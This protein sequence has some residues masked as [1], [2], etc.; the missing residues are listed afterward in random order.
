MPTP[1][2]RS[3]RVKI[4]AAARDTIR[5]KGY[6]ATSVEDLCVGAGVSKGAFFHHF[7]SKEDLAVAAADAWPQTLDDL[8]AA[9]PYHRYA[10]PLERVLGYID[11]RKVILAGDLAKC[12]CLPGTMVQEAFASSPAIRDA[13]GRA[14]IAHCEKI[15]ADIAAAMEVH[16]L[17][18]VWTA[19]SLALHVQAVL[20][21]AFIL[22][23]ACGPEAGA[24][25][26]DHL[27]HYVEML[28][29]PSSPKEKTP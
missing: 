25:S 6:A 5:A 27:R 18:P 14:I 17:Q 1:A 7:K 16:G 12:S 2:K 11:F 24:Q 28:F 21:G 19:N 8:F 15:E 4:L 26:I 22:A 3:A 20:Q 10:A 29:S 9:A 23:K 13:C